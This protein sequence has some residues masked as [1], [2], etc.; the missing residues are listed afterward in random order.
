[1]LGSSIEKRG[2]RCPSAGDEWVC[3]DPTAFAGLAT[4]V[5]NYSTQAA[6]PVYRFL[7]GGQTYQNET[8]V[9]G[10][11]LTS[12][13][14]ESDTRNSR[15]AFRLRPSNSFRWRPPAPRLCTEGQGVVELR[16]E[17]RN[18]PVSMVR[19]SS[20]SGIPTS[21]PEAFSP[22]PRRSSTKNEF[23]A[24]VA[25]PSGKTNSSFSPTTMDT[26][27]VFGDRSHGYQSIPTTTER[28]GD[29][30]AFPQ[31]IYDPASATGTGVRTPFPGKCYP[32]QPHLAGFAVLPVVSSGAHEWQ[33]PEQLTWRLC[34]TRSI[35]TAP[36]TKSTTY[37]SGQQPALRPL[38]HRQVRQPHRWQSDAD[39][40]LD[41]ARA[42]HGWR[43]VI[44]SPLWLRFTI[45]TSSPAM[46]NQFSVGLSRLFISFDEQH[47]LAAGIP[48]RRDSPA[49]RAESRAP[50]FRDISFSGNNA[51]VSW[52]G[53]QLHA[54][55]KPRT[56]LASRT[57]CSGPM[58][59]TTSLSA[60]N[61]RP[62]RTTKFSVSGY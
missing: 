57:A 15:S 17:V 34:R 55:T 6:G 9:E 50:V 30:S 51:P 53:N 42:V 24:T 48:G 25:V 60:S 21:T 13:G 26:V 35:T 39:Q 31:L 37:L 27:Y 44:E 36:R 45:A 1:V 43:G 28:T 3:Q 18:Q 40:H 56:P 61:G 33:Y 58:G 14:T 8:Y 49:C 11:A 10:L 12:A 16:Y 52:D 20:T 2:L 5:D 32:H 38:Q 59:S 46:V 22:P 29:F 41:T 4:G 54:T 62:C 7:H 23:G 19:F 47:V